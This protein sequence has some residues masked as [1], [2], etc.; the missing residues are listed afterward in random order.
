MRTNSTVSRIWNVT[1]GDL[2]CELTDHLPGVQRFAMSSD[3]Q[4]IALADFTRVEIWETSTG[5]LRSRLAAD[6]KHINALDF[7]PNG[8]LLVTSGSEAGPIARICD[9]ATGRLLHELR[10]HTDSV[11]DAHFS[12]D[13]TLIVTACGDGTAR[14]WM[15]DDGHLVATLGGHRNALFDA[16]FSPDGRRVLTASSDSTARIHDVSLSKPLA[17]LIRLARRRRPRTLSPEEAQQFLH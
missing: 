10:G 4:L 13:G 1:T 12:P 7:N 3:G 5:R 8:T 16:R 2:V 17:E 9:T 11:G 6:Q 15:V 14:V